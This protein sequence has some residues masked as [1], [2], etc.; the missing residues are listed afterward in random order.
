MI[1]NAAEKLRSSIMFTTIEHQQQVE[2]FQAICHFATR[3]LQFPKVYGARIAEGVSVLRAITSCVAAVT[4]YWT[5]D[6]RQQEFIEQTEGP[7]G[8]IN[9]RSLEPERW[10]DLRFSLLERL[11]DGV[12]RDLDSVDVCVCW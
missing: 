7:I 5:I 11:D 4:I 6:D 9:F 12:E 3:E 1:R 8:A 2:V 10:R